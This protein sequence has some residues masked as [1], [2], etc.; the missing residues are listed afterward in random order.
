M[1]DYISSYKSQRAFTGL[2][3]EADKP[4]MSAELGVMMAEL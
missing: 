2:D 4:R 1:I 3:L